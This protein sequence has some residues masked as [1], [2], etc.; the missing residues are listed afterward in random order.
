M[1]KLQAILRDIK[2][3]H[4]VFALPFAMMSAFLAARGLPPLNKLGWILVAMFGARSAAMAFNR[5]VDANIDAKNQRT[6]DR[7]LPSGF[8]GKGEY[9]VF[10]AAA[11]GAF[12]FACAMLNPL[13][14]MLSPM[15]LAV[16]FFYSFTKRFTWLSH[17]F[18]GLALSLAPIGAWAAV[19][20][21]IGGASVMVGL[22][23][24]FW[25]AGL[26]IIYAC[27]DYQFDREHGLFS[28]PQK[29]GLAR[30]LKFSSLFHAIMVLFLLALPLARPLGAVYLAGVVITAA[31]LWYEHSI[32]RPDDLKRVNAAFFNLN[33]AISVLLMFFVVIDT[34]S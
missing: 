2:I 6:R 9:L 23:V 18:L 13:C 25:L 19:A 10:L 34:I 11:I 20:N 29:F 26:D 27:Q 32:V 31:I 12:V 3:Q 16:V 30:S 15:A 22:A 17:F 14:L 5:V 33:G 21:E 7:A 1:N 24:V 4:T 28:F 8:V